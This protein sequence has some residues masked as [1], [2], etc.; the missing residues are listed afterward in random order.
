MQA[1]KDTFRMDKEKEIEVIDKEEVATEYFIEPSVVEENKPDHEV[2]T[3][4]E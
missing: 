3:E 2:K 4:V 1:Q